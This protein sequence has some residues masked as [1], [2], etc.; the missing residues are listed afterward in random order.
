MRQYL[1]DELTKSQIEHIWEYLRKHA[2]PSAVDGLFWIELPDDL[3]AEAQYAHKNCQPFCFSIE[4]GKD[5]LKLE[6]L[7]RSK[8]TLHCDCIQYAT[9]VQRDFILEFAEKMLP[10]KGIS[11]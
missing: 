5:C 2:Q 11:A 4:V 6:F 10:E 3:L 7:I 1:I 8:Q 9:K